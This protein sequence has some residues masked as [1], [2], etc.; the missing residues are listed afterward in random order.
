MDVRDFGNVLFC[1][2]VGEVILRWE[3]SFYEIFWFDYLC[4]C[5]REVIGSYEK[6]PSLASR[7]SVGYRFHLKFG[8]LSQAKVKLDPY[9]TTSVDH[10]QSI[11]LIL[12]YYEQDDI[13]TRVEHIEF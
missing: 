3:N 7:R 10:A 4:V 1:V 2:Y 6:L 8:I 12:L 11:N 9:G 13:C 5:L